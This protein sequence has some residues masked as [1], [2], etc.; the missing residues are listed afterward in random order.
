MRI[1]NLRRLREQRAFTQAELADL[2]GVHRNTV[3]RL[4]RGASG[5]HPNVLRRLARALRVKPSEL[6]D[7]D[8][9]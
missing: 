8:H 3:V 5:V 1:R 4:E 6:I 9:D 2:A 7:T